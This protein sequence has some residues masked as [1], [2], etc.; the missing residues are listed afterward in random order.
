MAEIIEGFSIIQ[1]RIWE[2]DSFVMLLPGEPGYVDPST[3]FLPVDSVV[4]PEAKKINL[5]DFIT[6]LHKEQGPLFPSSV[7][8]TE[9]YDLPFNALSYYL[10]IDAW[11]E[12]TEGG[13]TYR[14]NIPIINFNKQLGGF[15]FT[16]ASYESGDVIDYIAFE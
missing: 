7:N 14:E 6:K 8:V 15:S 3:I 4:W 12:R 5:V 13:I 9:S 11:R 10:K 2:L 1:K 16:L